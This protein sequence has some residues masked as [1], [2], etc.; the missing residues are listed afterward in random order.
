M[1]PNRSP[2]IACVVLVLAT[3]A[4]VLFVWRSARDG[5]VVYCAHDAVYSEQLLQ[6][7]EATTG[8]PVRIRFDTEG[9]KSLG[10]VNLLVQEREHPRCDV[11][12]NNELLGTLDLQQEGLLQ[13]YQG[14]GY[15]RIPDQY[16][17]PE[18]YWTG[19]A[20]RLR[21]VIFNTDRLAPTPESI[22]QLMD[23]VQGGYRETAVRNNAHPLHRAMAFMGSRETGCVASRTSRSRR[24]HCSG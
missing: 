18:G 5:L 2:W 24:V 12:W 19:F 10:L 20:G 1:N 3:A 21:V 17:D 6:E 8:I 9:T 4:G 22:D 16:K 23:P 15:Q 14:S 13:P 11:F 7:F